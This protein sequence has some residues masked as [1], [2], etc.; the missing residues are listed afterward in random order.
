MSWDSVTGHHK[1][2]AFLEFEV[3]EAAQLAQDAMNGKLMGGRNL[4]VSPVGRPANMPQAQPII[5]MVGQGQK[6]LGSK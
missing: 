4:K 5:D 2:F 6:L 3:P 1:G